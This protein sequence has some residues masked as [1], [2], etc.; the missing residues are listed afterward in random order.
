MPE[1]VFSPSGLYV[2]GLV[3]ATHLAGLPGVQG[4]SERLERV[5]AEDRG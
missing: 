2:P 1:R 5:G 3:I 4:L